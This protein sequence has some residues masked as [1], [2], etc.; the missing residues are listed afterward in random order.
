MLSL[1]LGLSDEE[2][3]NN[4]M[5]SLK[6]EKKTGNKSK[7]I[8]HDNDDIPNEKATTAL[9]NLLGGSNSNDKKKKP[10][11]LDQ[12]MSGKAKKVEHKKQGEKITGSI[13]FV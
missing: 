3:D 13:C 5:T 2:A 10:T 9:D 11:M 4:K 12:I 6:S 1:F 7:Q 8:H